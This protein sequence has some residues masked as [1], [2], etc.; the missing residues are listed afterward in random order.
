MISRGH[1]IGEIIDLLGDIS[2]QV[3]NRC[4]VGLFDLNRLIED[5]F[6]DLLNIILEKNLINLNMSTA[7]P[8]LPRNSMIARG[9]A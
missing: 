3:T 7:I 4:S 8:G 1:F 5:V 2:S 9:Q 6:K